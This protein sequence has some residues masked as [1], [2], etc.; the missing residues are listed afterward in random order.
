MNQ[1]DD[2]HRINRGEPISIT[3]HH[4]RMRSTKLK[5]LAADE[6]VFRIAAAQGNMHEVQRLLKAKPSIVHSQDENGW[7]AIHEAAR[8]GHL[9][10]MKY[11]VQNGADIHRRVGNGYSALKIAQEHLKPD[12]E[13]IRYLQNPMASNRDF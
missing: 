12:H 11:L 10:V 6:E 1:K 4:S 8:G 9:E 13:A 3:R 5:N 7:Q 2:E